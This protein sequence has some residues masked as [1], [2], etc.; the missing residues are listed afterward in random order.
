[1]TTTPDTRFTSE[2]SGKIRD[3]MKKGLPLLCPRC[4]TPLGSGG[5]IAGGG[6]QGLYVLYRCAQC[7]RAVTLG[8]LRR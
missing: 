6:T 8:D 5:P 2:E 1:M 4:G 3:S 7:N